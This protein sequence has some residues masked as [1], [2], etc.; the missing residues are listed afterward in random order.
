MTIEEKLNSLEQKELIYLFLSIPIIVFIFYYNFTY[1]QLV[2]KNKKLIKT[3]KSKKSK[4]SEISSQIREVKKSTKLLAPTRKKLEELK[5]D[6]KYISYYFDT[7]TLLKLSDNK[8][9][10]ILNGL[11][12]KSNQLNLNSSFQI[13]WDNLTP[14]FTQTINIDIDGSGNYINIIRYLQFI[15]HIKSLVQVTDVKI[16][17]TNKPA[18]NTDEL[19]K[20]FIQQK[21]A[22]LSSISFT[23]SQYSEKD[24]NYLK[25]LAKERKIDISMALNRY[26]PNN[27]DISYSGDFATIKSL[28]K[29][30]KTKQKNKVLN[31]YNLKANLKFPKLR[32]SNP[33]ITYFHIKIKIVG[34]K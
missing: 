11:L 30:L 1:P 13:K 19:I 12:N 28:L 21:K 14:P 7:L 17:T 33:S 34:V 32:R 31:F 16:S 2:D 10:S 5:E 4:L 15:E 3:E 9:Y 8:A 24:L 23:L 27:I 22:E 29:T 25:Y 20:P 26:N 6:F 18:T